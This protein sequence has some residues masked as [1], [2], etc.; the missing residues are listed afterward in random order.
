M[1]LR[2]LIAFLFLH[3]SFAFFAPAYG[4]GSSMDG[5]E[6]PLPEARFRSLHEAQYVKDR[7]KSVIE[8]ILKQRRLGRSMLDK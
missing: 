6:R 5:E 1:F 4:Y 3:Y 7:M 8:E 2:L